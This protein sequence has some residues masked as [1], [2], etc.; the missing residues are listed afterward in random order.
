MKNTILFLFAILLLIGFNTSYAQTNTIITGPIVATNTST[1]WPKEFTLGGSGITN[2]K[3]HDSQFGLAGTFSVQPL[4]YPIWFGI[5]QELSW[6]P[7]FVAATDLYSDY[8]FTIVTDKLYLNTGWSAG[9]TY[10][11]S[12]LGWRT[13]PEISLEYYTVGNAFI[14]GGVNYDLVTRDSSGWHTF[15]D[16]SLRYVIGIGIAW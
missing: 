7:T 13:G 2:P 5:N 6:S 8:I 3:T 10:D 11:T 9:A 16:N 15:G 1:H 4:S 12:T 14:F